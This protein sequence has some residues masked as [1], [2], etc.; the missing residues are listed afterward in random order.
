MEWYKYLLSLF[1]LEMLFKVKVFPCSKKGE[2]IKT[3]KDSLEVKVKAKPIGG[4]AN[5]ETISLLADYFSVSE[6]KVKLVKGFK[7]RNKIFNIA[8]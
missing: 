1:K 2:L 5:R 4:N 7:Q 6:D 8:I 3:S